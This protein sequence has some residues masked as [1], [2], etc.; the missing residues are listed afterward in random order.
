MSSELDYSEDLSHP[1]PSLD[2]IDVHV[3]RKTGGSDLAVVIASPLR[4]DERSMN[5]LLRK[6]QVYLEFI[7][8]SEYDAQCGPPTPESTRIVVSVHPGSDPVVFDALEQCQPWVASN[9]AS[10]KVFSAVPGALD[11]LYPPQE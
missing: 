4:G 2:A 11:E 6:I 7:G 3:V 10:L 9:R 8:S 1:I 5:R